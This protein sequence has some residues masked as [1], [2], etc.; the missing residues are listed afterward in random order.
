ME[1]ESSA[2]AQQA[3]ADMTKKKDRHVVVKPATAKS[4][5]PDRPRFRIQRTGIKNVSTVPSDDE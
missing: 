1:F 3:L 5:D 4:L 2:D